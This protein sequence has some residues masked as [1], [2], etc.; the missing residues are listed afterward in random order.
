MKGI[1]STG[2]VIV[3]SI[4]SKKSELINAN[5]RI[6]EK[7]IALCLTILGY[8]PELALILTDAMNDAAIIFAM[9]TA[10]VR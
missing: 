8:F 7:M 2:S 10:Y 9:T 4:G 5:K 1:H 3:K 6:L